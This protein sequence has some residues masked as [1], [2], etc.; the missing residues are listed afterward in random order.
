MKTISVVLLFLLIASASVAQESEPKRDGLNLTIY[1]SNLGVVRDERLI[2]IQS[3]TSTIKLRDVSAEIDPTTVKIAS[4]KHRVLSTC[5]NRIMS[6]T[7]SIRK[8]CFKNTSIKILQSS[9]IKRI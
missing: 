9:T 5:S 4:P 1:N 6:T 2:N 8:R 7:S 3:G